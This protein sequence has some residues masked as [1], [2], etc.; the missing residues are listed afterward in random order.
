MI[1]TFQ[2]Y[3]TAHSDQS[4]VFSHHAEPTHEIQRWQA[5]AVS[6]R[7]EAVQC[8]SAD[9]TGDIIL[10]PNVATNR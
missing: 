5:I 8:H 6:R 7:G 3:I 9:G 4:P 10:H 1:P 2:G